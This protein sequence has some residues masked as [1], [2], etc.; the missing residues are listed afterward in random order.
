MTVAGKRRAVR[1]EQKEERRRAIL[2]AAWALFRESPFDA[3]TMAAVAERA[4]LAKGTVYL[5]FAT[6]EE[7]FLALGEAQ[8]GAWFDEVDARLAALDDTLSDPVPAVVEII[9][10]SIVARE[11][12]AR[13]LAIGNS[14]LERNIDLATALRFKR[15]LLGHTART[16]AALERRLPFLG[17]RGG[18]A[19]LMQIHAL[20]VGFW[21]LADP[22]PVVRQALREPDL[23]PLAID[24]GRELS[25]TLL[26]LLYGLATLAGGPGKDTDKNGTTA[27][28]GKKGK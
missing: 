25:R 17:P 3:V 14:V 23:S 20:V 16:G 1:D 8:L 12:L 18:A 28:K 7:L 22:A 21:L 2:D 19:L 13:L 6:K 10:G 15:L 27:T 5:Y 24:F 11:D 26:A 4:G 9:G